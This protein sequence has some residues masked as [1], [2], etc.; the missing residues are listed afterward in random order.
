MWLFYAPVA[1]WIALLIVRYRGV[2]ALRAANPGM[3]DG[4]I[5]GESKYE[6]L[7]ALPATWTAPTLLIPVGVLAERMR[8]IAGQIGARGWKFPLVF[9]PDVGQRGA[10]VKLIRGF[11]HARRYLEKES[12]PVV[13]QPFHP[14]P[15]EAGV[16]YYRLPS[17]SRGRILSI[18][19]K[20]FPAAVGD[21][22]TTLEQLIWNDSR[23]RMQA[24]TFL[25]RH[26]DR[27]QEIPAAGERVAL[28]M[29][30]NHCQG[31]LFR[32]GQH[33]I[34]KALE[35]RIDAIAREYVGFF[36]G[37]FDIRYTDVERFKAGED[38]TII[39]LNGTTAESTNIYDPD[40]SLFAAYRQLF[41]QWQLV[42]EIGAAN[43]ALGSPSISLE[44]LLRLVR[45][46]RATPGVFAVAD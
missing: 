40:G 42:F 28:V 27:R 12:R 3:R 15:Y 1:A 23:L 5:V 9:K 37:R 19:D 14:G 8:L 22:V 35:D 41:R 4:G 26:A 30:G 34:T 21:G 20:Q 2:G 39:E 10:G 36:I 16:F 31:T 25:A 43:L 18:T 11:E 29:A 17:W 33:L 7:E 45:A 46:Q 6:I 38:F 13:V 24:H 44:E 32:D